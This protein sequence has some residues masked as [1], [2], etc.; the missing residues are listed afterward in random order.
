M[1]HVNGATRTTTPFVV[2]PFEERGAI[3]APGG[4]WVAYVSNKSG[5]N[6]IYALPY[7]GPGRE[8]TMSVGGGQE[9]VWGP[10]GRELFY[11]S[12][13]K[14][15]VVRIEES[16]ASL[17]VGAPTRV[18][19]DHYQVDTSSALGGNSNYDISPDGQ[20]FV[21]VEEPGPPTA[22][23]GVSQT[24]RLHLILNWFEELKAKVPRN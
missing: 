22:S 7:P 24:A 23:G 3:F 20:R 8:I 17:T 9:P 14:L 6:E 11:R 21:M 19:D 16:A 2:T 4:H 18:F 13:G 5:R 15:L 12:D 10:S 1:L